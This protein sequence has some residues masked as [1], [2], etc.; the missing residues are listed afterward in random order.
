MVT[1]SCPAE[2][3]FPVRGLAGAAEGGSHGPW[4][5]PEEELCHAL[6]HNLASLAVA[7]KRYALDGKMV[8]GHCLCRARAARQRHRAVGVTIAKGVSPARPS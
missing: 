7:R 6:E 1:V 8:V 4:D 3:L 5:E 2:G